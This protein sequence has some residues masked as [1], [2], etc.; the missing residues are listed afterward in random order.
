MNAPTNRTPRTGGGLLASASR[1]MSQLANQ[2]TS[3]L[4]RKPEEQ[5]TST[6]QGN[7][8]QDATNTVQHNQIRL[9][10]TKLDS[11]P[12]VNGVILHLTEN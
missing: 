8:T 12:S 4:R 1:S 3:L 2:G 7:T 9:Y 5:D 6:Q 11:S 10:Q